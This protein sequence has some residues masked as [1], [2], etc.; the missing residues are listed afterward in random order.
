MYKNTPRTIE[1]PKEAVRQEIQ[2]VSVDTLGKL[3]QNLDKT[4]SSV[5][6]CERRPVSASIMSRSCFASFPVC[7]YKFSSHYLNN[8][9]FI[10]NN[11]GPLATESPCIILVEYLQPMGDNVA[12]AV[13]KKMIKE[14]PCIKRFYCYKIMINVPNITKCYRF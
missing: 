3:F 8:I 11:L 5:L 7:V 6:G 9:F 1:Q 10:D 2:A 13:L 12:V 14:A 4:H